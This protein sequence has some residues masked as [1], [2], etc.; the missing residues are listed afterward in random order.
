MS[1]S[2][3]QDPTDKVKAT[4]KPDSEKS[5]LEKGQESVQSGA[6]SVAGKLQPGTDESASPSVIKAIG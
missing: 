5:P 2:M 3:R 4:V 6:D 1:D